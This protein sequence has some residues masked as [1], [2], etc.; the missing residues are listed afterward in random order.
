[1]VARD[2]AEGQE[3]SVRVLAFITKDV[4]SQDVW[5]VV[6]LGEL[7]YTL[8]GVKVSLEVEDPVY[9]LVEERRKVRKGNMKVEEEGKLVLREGSWC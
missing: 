6:R 9:I 5:S 7:F 8:G 1:M 2:E 3:Y 4:I